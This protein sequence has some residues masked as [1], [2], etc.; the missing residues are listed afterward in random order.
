MQLPNS[1]SVSF[2]DDNFS[3]HIG[4]RCYIRVCHVNS[5]FTSKETATPG[6]AVMINYPPIEQ[7]KIILFDLTVVKPVG[8]SHYHTFNAIK[9]RSSF[10]FM[11]DS[12]RNGEMPEQISCMTAIE[13]PNLLQK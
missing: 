3:V 10:L 7:V 5:H 2:L 6:L 4:V 9:P 12:I 13:M 11:L 1:A 8:R